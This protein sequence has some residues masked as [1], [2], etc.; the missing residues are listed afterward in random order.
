MHV[1]QAEDAA[2]LCADEMQ[3]HMAP[4]PRIALP[5]ILE[6]RL[7]DAYLR[8]A[9]FAALRALLRPADRA[10]LAP[11]ALESTLR[12]ILQ[13][14]RKWLR[15][16]LRAEAALLFLGPLNIASH[17]SR[18]QMRIPIQAAMAL[19]EDGSREL[20][21]LWLDSATV[22]HDMLQDLRRRGLRGAA[23][24]ACDDP[25]EM[26]EALSAVFPGMP[27]AHCPARLACAPLRQM[28]VRERK[29]VSR[30]LAD[31]SALP[32][33]HMAEIALAQLCL[34]EWG[35]R[36]PALART[37]RHQKAAIR[38]FLALPPAVRALIA[39]TSVGSAVA[40]KLQRGKACVP[41]NCPQADVALL[42]LAGQLRPGLRDWKVAPAK[43][44]G[45]R[46]ELDVMTVQA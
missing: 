4:A 14:T 10:E 26:A 5:P 12:D 36:H 42:W 16:P 9:D 45:V 37:L 1:T 23:L 43:W 8:G 46:R 40:E 29:A 22:R 11:A 38:D 15:R 30:Q 27:T 13:R 7:L 34:S 25:A 20:L 2:A 35:V 17:D 6:S 28:A 33:P 41:Q 18:E 39:T 44:N 32:D 21:G 19:H 3:R 24:A 31:I